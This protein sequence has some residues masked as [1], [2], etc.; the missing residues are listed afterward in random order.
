MFLYVQVMKEW[1]ELE[2]HYQE[3]RTKDPKGAEDFKKKMTGRF[4]KTVE[5]LEEEGSAEKRQ[6]IS[7]HQQRVMTIINLR[8]KSAM[9]CFTQSLDQSP[10][11]TKRIEKCLEKLLRALEKDRTHTLHHFRHLLNSYTKQALKDKEAMLDHLDDLIRMANQSIQMLDRVPN[12]ADKIRRRMIAFW[13][14][15]RGIPIDEKISKE[16]ELAI[17]DRYEEE[18]AQKQQEKERQK[19][20]EEQRKQELREL[21]DEKRRVEANQKSG[22]L[23]QEFDPESMEDERTGTSDEADQNRHR[24]GVVA[25]TPTTVSSTPMRSNV[26]IPHEDEET[27]EVHDTVPTPKQAYQQS[28]AFHHNEAVSPAQLSFTSILIS[29]II[30]QSYSIRREPYHQRL[31]WNG[32]VYITLAFAGIA[33][34]T[35]TIVGIVLLRKHTQR[36]PH[37]QGFVEVDQ[38]VSP[39]ERHVANMQINGYE[40][41]TYKYFEAAQPQ[42]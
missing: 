9:D 6:L 38:A 39:E 35:A 29:I 18:V 28:Q 1:S 40:N 41:P 27:N 21:Q 2:E 37:S 30:F 5:A 16:T 15:L 4:Q 11:K 14:N 32:S 25:P 24:G 33:L 20:I 42:A 23:E 3:M 31:R 8:K 17:M 13:H 22:K 10:P 7:M 19:M 12:I 36:S 34:L 26:L